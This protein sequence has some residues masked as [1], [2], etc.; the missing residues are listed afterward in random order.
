MLLKYIRGDI[1]RLELYQLAESVVEIIATRQTGNSTNPKTLEY[2]LEFDK[3]FSI[4]SMWVDYASLERLSRMRED[5]L[6]HLSPTWEAFE[7]PRAHPARS[8]TSARGLGGSRSGKR[9]TT[10]KSV[11]KTRKEC[12][13]KEQRSKLTKPS[14]QNSSKIVKQLWSL[15]AESTMGRRISFETYGICH[16][17]RR[18][19]AI[20]SHLVACRYS[21]LKNGFIVPNCLTVNGCTVYN[22]SFAFTGSRRG[23]VAFAGDSEVGEYARA[24]SGER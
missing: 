23:R 6:P 5:L 19:K 15:L 9:F 21:S 18:V 22:S 12:A 17:C 3:G 24:Q 2:L 16:H 14:Q 7:L 10:V 4:K 11:V 13:G 1:T 20:N 8:I